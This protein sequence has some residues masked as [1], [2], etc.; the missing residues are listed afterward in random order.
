MRPGKYNELIQKEIEEERISDDR[1]EFSSI[2]ANY[3]RSYTDVP[4]L[5]NYIEMMRYI[6]ARVEAVIFNGDIELSCWSFIRE[7]YGFI[8]EL[9]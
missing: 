2:L 9:I 8:Q 5:H 3:V 7:D 1:K 6:V 4:L